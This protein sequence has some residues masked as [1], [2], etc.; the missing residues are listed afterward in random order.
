MIG[1]NLMNLWI[2]IP[3]NNLF[4]LLLKLSTNTI[5]HITN[6]LKIM[7]RFNPN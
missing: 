7:Q 5:L 1:N 2:G 3:E 4:V 6:L